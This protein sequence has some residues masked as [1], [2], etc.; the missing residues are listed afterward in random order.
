MCSVAT[1]GGATLLSS[2]GCAVEAEPLF[3]CS[4]F[5]VVEDEVV[6]PLAVLPFGGEGEGELAAVVITLS[7]SCP[8]L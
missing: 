4:T 6:V 3:V 1:G 2:E 7:V 8:W 5:A